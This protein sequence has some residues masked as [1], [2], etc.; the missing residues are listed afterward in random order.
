M[1]SAASS[2]LTPELQERV[3]ALKP[4]N[5]YVLGWTA[6]FFASRFIFRKFSADFANRFVSIVHAIV[7]FVLSCRAVNWADPFGGVGG[8][9][10]PEQV[11]R[12]PRPRPLRTPSAP[13]AGPTRW[14]PR[15]APGAGPPPGGRYCTQRPASYLAHA[16]R[17]L[18]PASWRGFSAA[19]GAVC[20]LSPAIL[21]SPALRAARRLCRG[22]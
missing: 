12:P 19:C 13:G 7:A 15:G 2:L 17:L 5:E 11:W 3:R 21:R 14:P 8:P 10:T 1:A 16:R 9:N 18:Q 22:R 20:P 4:T 6:M